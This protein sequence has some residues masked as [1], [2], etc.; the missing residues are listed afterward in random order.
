MAKGEDFFALLLPEL[1]LVSEKTRTIKR[2]LPLYMKHL[3]YE[4][5]TTYKIIR[6]LIDK[7]C[8]TS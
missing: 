4:N 3:P 6:K 8:K 5:R 2:K 1:I 7:K